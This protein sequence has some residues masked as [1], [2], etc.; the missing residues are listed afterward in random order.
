VQ[1]VKDQELQASPCTVHKTLILRPHQQELSHHV[2]GEQDLWRVLPQALTHCVARFAG[3]FGECDREIPSSSA[4][5]VSLQRLKRLELRVDKRIH[6]I[7]LQH[8]H[9]IA[10]RRLPHEAVDDRQE[11]G[12][13]L[14]RAGAAGDDVALGDVRLLNRFDLVLVQVKGVAFRRAENARGFIMQH[15]LSRQHIHSGR[16]TISRAD[17]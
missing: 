12:Q 8:R 7:D 11:V 2:V 5:V 16:A 3:E 17:L 4:L 6:W 9:P 14:A 15:T 13:A 10:G 1:L